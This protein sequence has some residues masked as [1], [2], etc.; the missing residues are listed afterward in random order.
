MLRKLG[1]GQGKREKKPGRMI[2]MWNQELGRARRYSLASS[3]S[4]SPAVGGRLS[5]LCQWN[6]TE[7]VRG[8]L[9]RSSSPGCSAVCPTSRALKGGLAQVRLVK[10][11]GIPC[12]WVWKVV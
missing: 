10:N 12:L 6:G 7:G 1:L 8:V 5:L 11:S 9:L 3:L 4:P 2:P